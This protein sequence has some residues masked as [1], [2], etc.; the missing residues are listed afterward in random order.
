MNDNTPKVYHVGES[1]RELPGCHHTV[2]DNDS[3]TEEATLVAV[4][5]VD[6]E[7]V[8]KGYQYL[9]VLDDGWE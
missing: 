9:T 2:S 8:K 3:T 5:V 1:F 4:A 6:T 7:V